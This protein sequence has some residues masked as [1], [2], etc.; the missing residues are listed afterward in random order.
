MKKTLFIKNALILTVSSFILRFAGIIFKVWLAAL[1]GS[2]GIGLYQLIFSVYALV[3]TFATSGISTAV[4]RLIA[5]ELALGSKKGVER[6]LNRSIQSSLLIAFASIIVVFFGADF[7]AT[8]FIGDIR[9]AKALKILPFSL[10]FMAVCSCF[11]GYFIARRKVTP[12]AVSQLAEQG[13]RIGI[14][15]LL[16]SIFKGKGLAVTCAAVMA[17]DL[18]SEIIGFLILEVVYLFDKG[19]LKELVGRKAPPFSVISKITSISLP[20][21]LGRYLNSLLR[22]AENV[23]V[24]KNLEKYPKTSGT[25]LSQFGMIKGMALPVLF[26]PSAILNSISTLLIPEISEAAAKNQKRLLRIS[27]EKIIKL[28]MIISFIFAAVFFVGGETIGYLV[29]KDTSVGFLIKALSPIVP[30]MYLDSIADGILKGLDQ[31]NFAFKTS[32]S[33]SVIRICLI[34]CLLPKTGLMGFIGIM[35]FS[36]FLTCFLNLK[37]LISISKAR[38]HFMSEIFMPLLCAAGVSAVGRLVLRVFNITDNL[39]YIMLLSVISLFLYFFILFLLGIIGL[40]DLPINLCPFKKVKIK[41]NSADKN[42]TSF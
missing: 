20:I 33:D 42:P 31:Q 36:N 40:D 39:V 41:H 34:L 19:K 11:R 12:N 10:P 30:F 32:I 15:A 8:K 26:F 21:T 29:Y 16:V 13:V 28:T 7:I 3:S 1:V 23:L 25:A 5:E 35:Y 2:E 22:T 4:T 37:R 27:C 17:G 18:V 9:A 6:I 24:P 14:V 38:L